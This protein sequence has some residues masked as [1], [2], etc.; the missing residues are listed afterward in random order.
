[1][2]KN[3]P[4]QGLDTYTQSSKIYSYARCTISENSPQNND[5]APW[6]GR[7]PPNYAPHKI[8][9]QNPTPKNTL[10]YPLTKITST[11]LR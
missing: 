6:H 8:R 3:P 10:L 2:Y 11:G 1:M 9:E 5:P 7:K 4:S